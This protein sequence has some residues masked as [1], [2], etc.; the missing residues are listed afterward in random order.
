[1]TGSPTTRSLDSSPRIPLAAWEN[2]LG[3]QTVAWEQELTRCKVRTAAD[4]PRGAT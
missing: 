3:V 2:E 4:E 1:M